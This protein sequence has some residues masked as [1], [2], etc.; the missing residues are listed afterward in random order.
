MN[1]LSAP[2]IISE[3]LHA[4]RDSYPENPS[5][6]HE[7]GGY[8]AIN[9]TGELVVSRWPRGERSRIT[10]P[11]LA[12]DNRYNGLVVIA[13]FHTHP[14]PPIDEAGREWE[15]GPS[16]SDRRWHMRHELQGFVVSRSLIYRIEATGMISVVGKHV[17]VLSG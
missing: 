10:P 2:A 5:N 4:W 3:L 15:Q 11:T 1:L 16:E 12:S 7:E 8:I 13:A 9:S 6:R 14:N 17:E